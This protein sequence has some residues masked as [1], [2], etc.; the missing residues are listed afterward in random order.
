MPQEIYYI[1]QNHSVVGLELHLFQPVMHLFYT[2]LFKN[3]MNLETGSP[4]GIPLNHQN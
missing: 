3:F 1:C 2:K 4:Q